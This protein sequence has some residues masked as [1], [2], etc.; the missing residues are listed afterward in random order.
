MSETAVLEDT[1]GAGRSRRLARGMIAST[2]ARGLTLAMPA[3]LIPVTYRYFGPTQYAAWATVIALTSMF[4]WSDLG[5]GNAL[6]TRLPAALAAG[7]TA[8]ARRLI[9]TAYS[10]LASV[11]L[12]LV[13][14]QVLTTTVVP[15]ERVLGL[16]HAVMVSG[17]VLICFGLLFL[18][19]PLGLIQRIQY[20]A[21]EVA[22][23]S[24]YQLLGSAVVFVGAVVAVGVGAGYLTVVAVVALASPLGSLL[25]SISFYRRRPELRPTWRPALGA[26]GRDLLVLGGA[27]FAV[28]AV[29]S[30]AFN[31]D[32]PVAA[33]VFGDSEMASFSATVRI[34]AVLGAILTFAILPLWPANASAL[35][36]G[37]VEW[38]RRTTK[39]M[40]VASAGL[41]VAAGIAL[42]QLGGPVLEVLMGDEF[43]RDVPLMLSLT[44][45]WAVAGG[46]APLFMVQNAVGHLKP[47]VIAWPLLIVVAIPLKYL[48]ATEVGFWA[49]PAVGAA[50][51]AA[52]MGPA[53][54]IGYRQALKQVSTLGAQEKR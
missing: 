38:V 51:Y 43:K 42:S 16:D 40:A 37:D 8:T 5:L 45:V 30:V 35:A 4:L 23:S 54:W 19:V 50:T 6:M 31:I 46:L 2:L 44:A 24:A 36:R 15:W 21:D 20:A 12:M 14:A 17:T 25:A 33:R 11:A 26:D 39:R 18:N 10:T 27:F 22:L 41:V 3:A 48:A 1:G 34:V 53:A 13:C 49:I 9:S 32:I 47:Q 29:S 7:D 52:L 28:Q